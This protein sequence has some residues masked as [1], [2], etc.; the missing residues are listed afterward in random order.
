MTVTR[1]ALLIGA[2]T[3]GL[4]GTHNDVESIDAVLAD[5][6]FE[7]RVLIDDNATREGILDGLDALIHDTDAGDPVLLYY[8]GHGG[9][10][11]NP[12][13]SLARPHEPRHYTCIVPVDHTRDDF[14]GIFQSELSC[15]L[16]E[17]ALRTSNITAVFDCCHA[18][19]MVRGG[20]FVSK[21]I[22]IP[23][24]DDVEAHREWLIAQGYD[25]SS[26]ATYVERSP[27]AVCI[28]ACAS[29]QLAFEVCREDGRVG[30]LLTSALADV[31]EEASEAATWQA[32]G[33]LVGA[34]VVAGHA[35]QV[36]EVHGPL[37]RALFS[38]EEHSHTDV[39]ILSS[40]E[41]VPYLSGGSLHGVRTGSRYLLMPPNANVG[42]QELALAEAEVVEVGSERARVVLLQKEGARTPPLGTRAFPGVLELQRH[43]VRLELPAGELRDA[44]ESM[45]AASSRLVASGPNEAQALATLS[46]DGE[47]VRLK[48]HDGL[49]ARNPW[50]TESLSQG[51]P[52][53]SALLGVL[54]QLA[55]VRELRLTWGWNGERCRQPLVEVEWGCLRDEVTRPL[56]LSGARLHVGE[57]IYVRL[58]SRSE[59]P[60]YVSILGVGVSR[61]IRL[62]SASQ[63]SGI[64]LEHGQ[65]YT[66]GEDGVGGLNGVQLLWRQ[67]VPMHAPQ[68][69]VLLVS[70]SARPFDLRCV[71]SSSTG[72]SVDVRV[73]SGTLFAVGGVGRYVIQF[74]LDPGAQFAPV[75]RSEKIPR[76]E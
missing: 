43:P 12:R 72:E 36:P 23:W 18:A 20:E 59:T 13:H 27:Q 24:R 61:G 15:K 30:S 73:R 47:F 31:L 38:T 26:R 66:L 56:P 2:Q 11:A 53:M 21:S 58:T 8:S 1:R 50:T 71:E 48:D 29:D 33:G 67:E 60:V 63:P 45:L 70:A 42:D 28:L 64:M 37:G 57:R 6:G 75:P 39:L 62:L 44:L 10:I 76:S 16:A 40:R 35:G 68:P 32:I 55:R 46:C 14:R 22:P 5:L 4:R 41:G 19:A 74:S 17:L 69:I 52:E 65:T 49:L 9:R 25:L 3:Y 7:R 54:E 51:T 34:R